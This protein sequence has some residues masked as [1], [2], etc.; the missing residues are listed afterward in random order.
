MAFSRPTLDQ[1]IQRI[2]AEVSSR[3]GL[4]PLLDRSL[5]KVIARVMAG[6]SHGLHGHLDF[7]ADQII[8][9]TAS[10]EN[11]ERWADLFGLQRRAATPAVGSVTFTGTNGSAIPSGTLIQRADG[12]RFTTDALATIA[13]GTATVAVTAETQGV[14][15]NTDTATELPLVVPVAGVNSPATVDSPGLGGGADIETDAQLR[16]RLKSFLQ[17]RPQGGSDAD[18]EAWTLEVS[19][20]TRVFVRGGNSGLGTV[21]V[22]FAVDD[23]PGGPIPDAAKVAEVQA[24]LNDT[25]RRDSR[26]VT[27]EVTAIAP[28]ETLQA[29]TLSALSPNTAAVQQAISAALEDLLLTEAEPGG[30]I[31]LN[32]INEAISTAPG[33]DSHTLQSPAS[34]LVIA[35]NALLV[36]NGV[37]F[38]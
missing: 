31:T 26:P 4:G 21:D 15:A 2:E 24:R 32:Q 7:I 16:T 30:T 8:P 28:L 20:V 14:A 9:T 3:L 35:D 5:L 27:A 1:L 6:A 36:F 38:P 10:T 17:A 13:A 22:F 29:F 19:G 25:T 37:T 33:E 12:Q 34:D 23:D 11:L 18:Y